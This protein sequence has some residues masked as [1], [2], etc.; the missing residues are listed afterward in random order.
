MAMSLLGRCRWDW[1]A[2]ELHGPSGALRLTKLETDLLEYLLQRTGEVVEREA[3]LRDVWNYAP[4]VQ[5]RAVANTVARLRR[6]LGED[7]D[8]IVT[9]YGRG[10]RLDVPDDGDLIG[11]RALITAIRSVLDEERWVCL[12]GVGGVGKTALARRIAGDPDVVWVDVAHRTTRTELVSAVGQAL[13]L[14][15]AGLSVPA[16]RKALSER[17]ACRVVVDRAEHLDDDVATALEDWHQLEGVHILMTSRRLRFGM[18]GVRVDP[19]TR[20]AA[21]RLFVLRAESVQPEEALSDELVGAVV[22]AV[23]GL[24]LAVELAAA[25]LR[26]LRLP[27]LVDRLTRDLAILGGGERS[28]HAVLEGSW[29]LLSE[30]EQATLSAAA[31]FPGPFQLD[32]LMPVV[33]LPEVELLDAMDELV[34][35]AL[36]VEARPDFRLL[37]VVRTVMQPRASEE[38]VGRF[39]ACA[40]ERAAEAYRLVYAEPE[41]IAARLKRQAPQ[42]AVAFEHTDDVGQRVQLAITIRS[43]DVMFG[44]V[45]RHL[46]LL[47]TVGLDDLPP[48]LALDVLSVRNAAMS[49]SDLGAW[50]A[51]C[52]GALVLA[53]DV[54]DPSRVVDAWTRQVFALSAV[55]NRLEALQSGEQLLAYAQAHATPDHVIGLVHLMLAEMVVPTSAAAVAHL[56][57]AVTTLAIRP[58]LQSRAMCG[59]ARALCVLGEPKQAEGHARSAL[60][61]ADSVQNL[62]ASLDARVWV[63]R[64]LAEQGRYRD[65]VTLAADALT[66]ARQ[67]GTVG[68]ELRLVLLCF[69]AERDDTVAREGLDRLAAR[70]EEVGDGVVLSQALVGAAFRRH[71]A[72]A[73]AAACEGYSDGA[74]RAGSRMHGLRSIAHLWLQLAEMELGRR[75]ALELPAETDE[76]ADLAWRTAD[77]WL[78]QGPALEPQGVLPWLVRRTVE[79]VQRVAPPTA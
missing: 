26:I 50:L 6:K 43:H 9:V 39:V 75:N 33:G 5:S 65:A 28:L 30:A 3:L 69:D 66:E 24:P 57:K 21:Q 60:R 61:L 54:G 11:R 2:R 72:G 10:F 20:E 14:D 13:G 71:R 22:G 31:L 29:A 47:H 16:V 68:S 55:R 77:R 62:A 12:Y 23:D 4:T 32:E 74:A 64:S 7:G 59:L 51:S 78:Q 49:G 76:Q 56:E 52:E 67:Y 25:R 38:S 35:S 36:V 34:R 8:C 15:R 40:V 58:D 48:P 46:G 44:H 41:G 1:Q 70:A 19:L 27:D 79:L 63:G 18:P 73:V 17:D 53:H 45:S 42:F 37:D